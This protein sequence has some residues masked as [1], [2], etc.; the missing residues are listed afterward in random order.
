MNEQAIQAQAASDDNAI[1]SATWKSR[2]GMALLIFSGIITG[3]APVQANAQDFGGMGATMWGAVCKFTRSP[4][5]T[6]IVGIAVLALLVAM[7]ANED[8]KMLSSVIKVVV[9]GIAI[10]YLPAILGILGFQGAAAC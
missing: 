6:V 4:V 3:L 5:V 10:L 9:G 2:K 7:A 8:N 1:F